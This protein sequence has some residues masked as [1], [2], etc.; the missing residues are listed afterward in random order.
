MEIRLKLP[1]NFHGDGS[2][3]GFLSEM[4]MSNGGSRDGDHD[5]APGNETHQS[6]RCR[7]RGDSSDA[8]DEP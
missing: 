6:Q 8:G 7:R 2:P 3:G 5:F 4:S 1:G